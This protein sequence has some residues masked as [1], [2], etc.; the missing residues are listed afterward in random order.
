M[1]DSP[2]LS[3]KFKLGANNNNIQHMKAIGV[4]ISGMMKE[5]NAEA[6]V[7]TVKPIRMPK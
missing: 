2:I 6:L 7:S 1:S 4:K 5:V 3:P